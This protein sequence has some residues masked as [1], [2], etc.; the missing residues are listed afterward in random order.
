MNKSVCCLLTY[1]QVSL[2]SLWD[3]LPGDVDSSILQDDPLPLPPV[4]HPSMAESWR[5]VSPLFGISVKAHVAG[6]G[7]TLGEGSIWAQDA[8]LRRGRRIVLNVQFDFFGWQQL[9]HDAVV[10][11]EAFHFGRRFRWDNGRDSGRWRDL[12]LSKR[13]LLRNR[14]SSN[15]IGLLWFIQPGMAI[16]VTCMGTFYR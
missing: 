15:Y 3:I 13:I 2:A 12:K 16:D 7:G 8:I 11:V 5:Q 9:P 6:D 1:L 14:L 10:G 4:R